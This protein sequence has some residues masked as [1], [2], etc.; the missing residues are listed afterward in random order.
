[1]AIKVQVPT[2]M[3]EAAGGNAEV[4]VAGATVKDALADLVRQY[5]ALGS[6]LFD[7]GKVRPY[8][9]IFV[10]DEDVRYLDDLDTK[11]T[12]GVVV[13]LIPAVAGG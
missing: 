6:K 12:D 11:V 13:A 1:M 10:N 8:V 5:P 2:P 7:G 4:A 3:R 9:N